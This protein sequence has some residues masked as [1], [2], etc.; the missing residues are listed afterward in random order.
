MSDFT[1]SIINSGITTKEVELVS[2]AKAEILIHDESRHDG[3]IH[4]PL[5][6]SDVYVLRHAKS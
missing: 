4:F 5:F 1:T 2:I 3:Y 6:A